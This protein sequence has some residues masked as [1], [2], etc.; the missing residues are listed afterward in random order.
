MSRY[1]STLAP[2]RTPSL[3]PRA[4]LLSL[5]VVLLNH[6]F[7]DVDRTRAVEYGPRIRR[8]QHQR[9]VLF[10]AVLRDHFLK[11]AQDL[12]GELVVSLLELGLRVLVGALEV[13]QALLVVALDVLALLVLQNHALFLDLVLDL[14]DV[15]FLLRQLGLQLVHLGLEVLLRLLSRIAL[16]QRALQ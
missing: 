10:R 3:I 6:L 2:K 14:L 16:I 5:G 11:L 7:R 8:L 9:I 4:T 15:A 12:P 13:A 1:S